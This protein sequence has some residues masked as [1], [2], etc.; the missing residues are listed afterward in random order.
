MFG[1]LDDSDNVIAE[2]VAPLAVRS[3]HPIFA[4]DTLS[5]SRHISRRTAQRW[6]IETRLEPLSHEAQELFVHMVNKG[7]SSTFN[8]YVPQ[9]YGAV[10]AKTSL[11][12]PQGTAAVNTN[13]VTIVTNSNTGFIPKGT[14]IKFSNQTKIYLTLTN[15]NNSTAGAYIDVY[16]ALKTAVSSTSFVTSNVKMVCLYDFD[17]LSGMAYSDGI[18]QDVGQV[19][20]VEA[21]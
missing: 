18:L 8:I 4:S 15:L 9:N 19:R 5:L 13:R 6:E 1:I 21:I 12:S 2:F 10:K 7:Y 16:P 17:T 3:N 20:L 14:F 11:S